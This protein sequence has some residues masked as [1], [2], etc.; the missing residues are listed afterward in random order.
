MCHFRHCVHHI[1][2]FDDLK[3]RYASSCHSLNFPLQSSV[4][5]DLG[6][7]WGLIFV[8]LL[9]ACVCVQFLRQSAQQQR[10]IVARH[11]AHF[12]RDKVFD[13]VNPRLKETDDILPPRFVFVDE[14]VEV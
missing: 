4:I 11:T 1:S 8:F 2:F 14:Y 10:R 6:C 7:R 13:L 5:N 9:F 3:A 12:V